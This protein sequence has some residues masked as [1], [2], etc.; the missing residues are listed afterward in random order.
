M[1]RTLVTLGRIL[2]A[3]SLAAPGGGAVYTATRVAAA[4]SR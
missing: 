1:T 4:K 3:A 2:A